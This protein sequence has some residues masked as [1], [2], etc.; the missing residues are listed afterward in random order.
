MQLRPYQ[1]ESLDALYSYW[2][3]G[4]GNGLIVLPTGAGKSLVAA[5]LV[6]EL[7]RDYP[8]LRIG[9]VTHVREL[10]AQNHKE[11]MSIW[12][13]APAGIYSAG[14]GRRDMHARI[15][16]CGIQSVWD[17]VDRLGG[18]DVLIV[19]EAHLLP[20]SGD[21]MYRKFI[22]RLLDKT[23][24]MRT[25]GLTA[26]PYRL[27]SGRLDKGKDALFD[28]IVYD[29]NVGDLIKD[30][31]LSPLLSKGMATTL[32]TTGVAKRGGDFVPGALEAAVNTDAITQA[33]VAEMVQL[34][35]DRRA[36]LA[37][38]CGVKHAIAVRD[39]VRGHGI[40]CETLSGETPKGERDRI[41]RDFS[42][43]RIRCLT[44]VM[45]LS[46]GFNVPH[47]DLIGLLR[48]TQSA[49]LFV[50]Q[51]GRALR[52]APG[53]TDALILDFAGNTRRHGPIDA[54]TSP[55]RSNKEM[56]S[57]VLAKECPECQTLVALA[58]RQ[59]PSCGY[60]WPV[61]S[62][63][64]R[65]DASADDKTPILSTG[66][67]PPAWLRVDG[68]TFHR[69]VKYGT[70]D[71]RPTM[72][73][74][75]RCGFTVYRE[76]LCFE[77]SGYA[78]SK[79]EKWWRASHAKYPIPD[80]VDEAVMRAEHGEITCPAEIMVRLEGKFFAVVGRR[81]FARHEAAA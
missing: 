25:V 36:W 2:R 11:L 50:Q 63:K 47:V 13:Q 73:V 4:G 46:I 8:D 56:E 81:G 60:E 37:F 6:R 70:P 20:R 44:S 42:A 75:Y 71:A 21:T 5:T 34:G 10:I 39:A 16:F 67:A 48:P 22:E 58:T 80:T 26:T 23:P 57:V 12:P 62:D 76:F 68:V 38:C 77:H 53:K 54:I 30:E 40:T 64:P 3:G 29:A 66:G 15:L 65:H 51:V 9:I 24:D 31:Y 61:I 72:R 19:D 59:C 78:R 7:L 35:Q 43:G 79:A 41:V 55:D 49:G 28:R 18:F 52:R 74:E 69:H 27:D 1:R 17:K 33:A 32:N 45:V 14:I